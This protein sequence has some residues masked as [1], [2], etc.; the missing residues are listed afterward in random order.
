[1]RRVFIAVSLLIV[2][3]VI[4]VITN[5]DLNARSEKHIEYI[6]EIE[7][8]V[9]NKEFLNA[10]LL[11]KKAADEYSFTDSGI[12]YNYYTHNDLSEIREILGTM[13]IYLKNKN[14]SEF[15][16]YSSLAKSRLNSII[17]KKK[18]SVE[19]IL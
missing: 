10:E 5:I 19:N 1:M 12:M 11:S 2:S 8:R 6:Y 7:H 15:Y 3:V 4:G 13:R 17:D 18:V 16:H 14:I 9:N